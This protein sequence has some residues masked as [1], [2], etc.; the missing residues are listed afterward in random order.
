MVFKKIS[1]NDVGL[2][3]YTQEK[4]LSKILKKD[5]QNSNGPLRDIEERHKTEALTGKKYKPFKR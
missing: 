2:F 3:L 5:Y 4:L 1:I